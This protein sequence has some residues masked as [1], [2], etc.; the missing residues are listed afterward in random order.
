MSPLKT[1]LSAALLCALVPSTLADS[2]G[3]KEWINLFNGKDL[4]DW[5]I[6]IRHSKLGE[7]THNTFRV[8]DGLLKVRY[9]QYPSF[10]HEFG[11]IFYT[12]QDFSYYRIELQYRFVGQQ[13]ANGP[14]W[15]NRNNGIMYH[16]Q[17]P[18]TMGLDQDFPL[19]MEYQLLGGLN[20]GERSTA[21]LCTPGT[22]VVMGNVLRKDHCINSSSATYNGDDW[23]NISL[24]VHG[25]ELAVHTVEGA[26][27]MR[28]RDLQKDDGSAL[29]RGYIA[30]QAESAPI[31]FKV[32]RLLNL[33]GCMDPEA[34]NYKSYLVK[35]DSKACQY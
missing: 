15:A 23:V 4:N 27:V 13:V 6:K 28:Y 16:A 31:D 14:A 24:E 35:H 8:E 11:H 22:H 29:E 34:N 2:A 3:E 26:E 1:C 19:S 33:E 30:L 9:D 21:N 5:A 7:N 25:R 12:P 17:A 32:V 18:E 10:D 20:E